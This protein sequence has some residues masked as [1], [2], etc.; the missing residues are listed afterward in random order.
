MNAA[1]AAATIAANDS[2]AAKGL[3]IAS[4]CQNYKLAVINVTLAQTAA[5][6]GNAT[7]NVTLSFKC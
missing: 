1:L 2:K 3:K 7:S 6:Q 4:K 5:C